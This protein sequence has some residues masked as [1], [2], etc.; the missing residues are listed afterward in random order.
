MLD[1]S[2][3]DHIITMDL[4]SSQIQGFFNKPVD[5]MFSLPCF[6]K[7]VLENYEINSTNSVVVSR[8][9]GGVKRLFI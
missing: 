2:G 1:V 5:N 6:A 9:S 4:N 3:V 8:N 7:L